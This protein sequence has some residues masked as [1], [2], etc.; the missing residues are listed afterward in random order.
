MRQNVTEAEIKEFFGKY[1]VIDEISIPTRA[2]IHENIFHVSVLFEKAEYTERAINSASIDEKKHV[3]RLST[4][5]LR[6][7]KYVSKKQVHSEFE[8]TRIQQQ[9]A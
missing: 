3:T 2:D 6:L 9:N 7:Q 4:A 5:E 1:G 8:N